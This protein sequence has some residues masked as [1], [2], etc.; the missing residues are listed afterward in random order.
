MIAELSKMEHHWLRM[1]NVLNFSARVEE[2]V[3]MLDTRQRIL[4]MKMEQAEMELQRAQRAAGRY[5]QVKASKKPTKVDETRLEYGPKLHRA[6]QPY[7]GMRWTIEPDLCDH[8][9]GCHMKTGD[10]KNYRWLCLRCGQ[11][12]K[13]L[14][15]QEKAEME[16][17]LPAA[18]T[19]VKSLTGSRTNPAVEGRCGRWINE[20]SNA[21]GDH[22]CW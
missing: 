22:T 2:S 14:T 11:Y 13:R 5:P 15:P 7:R 6:P 21:E 8:P 20:S 3:A 19:V 16:A 4:Q 18:V 9:L 12:W 10:S 1:L 17:N